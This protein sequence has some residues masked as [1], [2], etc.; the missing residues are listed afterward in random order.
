MN[1]EIKKRLANLSK[2]Y[3]NGYLNDSE[4]EEGLVRI[5]SLKVKES[6]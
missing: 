1:I 3:I 5:H 6:V 4:F 2:N